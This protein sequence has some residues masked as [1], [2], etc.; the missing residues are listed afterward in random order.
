[1]NAAKRQP[2]KL[3]TRSARKAERVVPCEEK[4]ECARVH[5]PGVSEPSAPSRPGGCLSALL[6]LIQVLT[7][8][9]PLRSS[10]SDVMK[11]S[12]APAGLPLLL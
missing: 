5:H 7:R 8:L 2:A 11:A 3:P 6:R 9:F 10:Y 4:V 1:M 12:R